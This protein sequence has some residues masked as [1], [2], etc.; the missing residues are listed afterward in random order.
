LAY[1][2]GR[3]IQQFVVSKKNLNFNVLPCN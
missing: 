2:F 3:R 1:Q